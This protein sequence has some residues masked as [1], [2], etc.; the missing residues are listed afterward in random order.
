MFTNEEKINAY[1]NLPDKI[2]EF[3]NSEYFNSNFK[4]I[5]KNLN[6]LIDEQGILGDELMLVI[7]GLISA[8]ELPN[9]IKQSLKINQQQ[10][11]KIIN[12]LNEKIF[13]QLRTLMQNDS[14]APHNNTKNT[15]ESLLN[16]ES[17]LDEIENPTPTVHPIS[18]ADQTI[19][20]PARPREII[21]V[22]QETKTVQA[23]EKTENSIASEFI[24]GK[25]TEIV[26][27]PNQRIDVTSEKPKEQPKKYTADPYRESVN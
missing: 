27:L 5:G 13:T 12:Q 24:T 14:D 6:L 25:L 22:P 8:S 23:T 16:K 10:S 3:L 21:G 19:S 18:I 26:S 17:I 2:K 20:G 15:Q 11:D 7:M 1:K 4:E 9:R